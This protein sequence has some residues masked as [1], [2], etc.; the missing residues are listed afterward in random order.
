MTSP[1]KSLALFQAVIEAQDHGIPYEEAAL[2]ISGS[3]EAWMAAANE[4]IA[5][6]GSGDMELV[7]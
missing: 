6:C 1:D 5:Y 3:A 4:L 7:D 2:K